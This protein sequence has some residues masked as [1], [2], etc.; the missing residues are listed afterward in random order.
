[1]AEWFKAHAWKACVANPHRGFESLSLRQFPFSA[2][3]QPVLILPAAFLPALD[4]GF[5]LEVVVITLR[6]RDS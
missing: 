1:M 2:V 5:L 3:F 6:P 4:C